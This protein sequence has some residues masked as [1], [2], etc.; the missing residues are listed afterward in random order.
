MSSLLKGPREHDLLLSVQV[1]YRREIPQQEGALSGYKP[2]F[3][4][5]FLKIRA[6]TLYL[7]V[8][9]VINFAA[10]DSI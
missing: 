1:R 9:A 4:Q 8:C 2:K 5:P 7:W 6:G 10:T 3:V